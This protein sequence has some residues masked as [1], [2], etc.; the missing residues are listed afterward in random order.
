ME[1]IHYSDMKHYEHVK[2]LDKKLTE[3]RERKDAIFD[4]YCERVENGNIIF[5]Y[6]LNGIEGQMIAANEYEIAKHFLDFLEKNQNS[7]EDQD[8]NPSDPF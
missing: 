4:L 6:V 8:I 1:I 5:S 7:N 3:F 2:M